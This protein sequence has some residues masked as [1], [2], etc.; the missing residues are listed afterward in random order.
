MAKTRTLVAIACALGFAV[1]AAHAQ[2]TQGAGKLYRYVDE[3]GKVHYLDRPPTEAAG[4]PIDQLNRQGAVLK[5]GEAPPTAEQLAAR[6]AEKRRQ[7]E[8]QMRVRE[9]NRRNQALLDTYSS[10]KDIDESRARAVAAAHDSIKDSKSKL[11]DALKRQEKLK[12]EAEFYQKR[13]MP[14]QLKQEVQNNEREIAI[15]REAI[16]KK[17]Q[18]IGS[19]N[20]KY[21]EDKRRYLEIT[22]AAPKGSSI[23]ATQTVSAGPTAASKR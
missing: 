5:Q 18:E 11:A 8:E 16:E 2:Q 10:E 7:Q 17:E 3:R 19:I 6:E 13:P 22:R 1:S 21:D 23:A 15:Q 14:A 12:A 20:T 4:K 9:E